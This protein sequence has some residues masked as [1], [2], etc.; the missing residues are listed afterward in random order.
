MPEEKDDMRFVE[1]GSEIVMKQGKPEDIVMDSKEVLVQ[2]NILEGTIDKIKE[3][4]KQMKANLIHGE[5]SIKGNQGR[6]NAIKRFEPKMISIQESKARTIYN[7]IKAEVEKK[8]RDEYIYDK[9]LIDADNK[10]QMFAIYQRAIAT[11]PRVAKELAPKIITKMYYVD[12]KNK[13][14]DILDNPFK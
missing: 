5:A 11:N 2:I 7:D 8:V 3:Q 14:E 6:L 4:M 9:A 10:V 12:R 1:R 13:K